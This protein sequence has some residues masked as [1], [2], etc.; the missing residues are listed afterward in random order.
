LADIAGFLGADCLGPD[1]L[2][3]DFLGRRHRNR[4]LNTKEIIDAAQQLRSGPVVAAQRSEAL[5]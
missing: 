1:F 2:G 3:P 5:V 4:C